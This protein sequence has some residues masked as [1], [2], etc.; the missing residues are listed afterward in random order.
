M[1]EVP[2]YKDTFGL[3][4]SVSPPSSNFHPDWAHAEICPPPAVLIGDAIA[5][6]RIEVRILAQSGHR[7][8]E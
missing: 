7:C 1:P 5:Q 2:G 4:A 6:Q 3:C 8:G